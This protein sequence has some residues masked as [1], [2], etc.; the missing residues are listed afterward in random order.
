MHLSIIRSSGCFQA[1]ALLSKSQPPFQEN[2]PLL[3]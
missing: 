3:V 1:M 2:M